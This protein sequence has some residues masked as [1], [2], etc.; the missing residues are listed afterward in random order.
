MKASEFPLDRTD[1]DLTEITLRAKQRPVVYR[2]VDSPSA[3]PAASP[4]YDSLLDYWHILF[5]SR[6]TLLSFALAGLFGAIAISLIQTPIYR[7]TTSIEIQGT[8]FM[9]SKNPT[10]SVRNS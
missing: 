1:G 3:E 4:G 10:D 2:Y 5:R 9:E 7:V 6:K 8:N